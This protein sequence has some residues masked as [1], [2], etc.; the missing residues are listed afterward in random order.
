[1]AFSHPP[2]NTTPLIHVRCF[3]LILLAIAI[4]SAP[5]ASAQ[6]I[7]Q[8]H[9]CSGTIR[10][11]VQTPD[12]KPAPGITVTAW[13]YNQRFDGLLPQMTTNSAG[14]FRLEKVCA[15][16]FA[17]LPNDREK[18]DSSYSVATLEFLYPYSVPIA[19]ISARKSSAAVTI[20]LQPKPGRITIQVVN[21]ATKA[22]LADFEVETKIPRWF[23]SPD[24]KYLFSPQIHDREIEIPP[25]KDFLL[26]VSAQ[27][28]R[29]WIATT[30][31]SKRIHVRPG[32]RQTLR[33][34]LQPV[35]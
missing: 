5:S 11:S 10:G 34:Q 23:H 20:I 15:G 22:D 30:G 21:A 32:S 8:G 3:V 33:V 19:K 4:S 12:G 24:V 1:M 35:S 31:S 13:P 27:G 9:D 18:L 17:V 28:F 14:Q 7:I 16:K 25:D 6:S 29:P 2:Q 26:R